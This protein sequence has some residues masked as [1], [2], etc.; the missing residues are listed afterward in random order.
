M[1]TTSADVA[2]QAGLTAVGS[3]GIIKNFKGEPRA[4]AAFD[5]DVTDADAF[6]Q[7]VTAEKIPLT[8]EFNQDNS[9]KIFNS[10]LKQQIL[11][12]A[13]GSDL[14]PGA[15]VR[16]VAALAWGSC[17]SGRVTRGA[18]WWCPTRGA[19]PRCP[20]LYALRCLTPSRL[21]PPSSRASWCSSRWTTRAAATSQ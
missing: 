18:A 5:G 12:W 7:F 6:K 21:W 16:A 8:I 20:G 10:G 13:A 17:G 14:E 4:T 19:P 11:L 1:D 3:V 2:K 15:K 9:D